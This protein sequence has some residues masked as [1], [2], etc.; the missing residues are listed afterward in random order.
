MLDQARQ[1]CERESLGNVRLQLADALSSTTIKADCVV[2][3]MVLHHFA[4]PAEAL[5]QMAG[6]LHP[7]GSLLVTDLCSHNQNWARRPAVISGWVL[8]RMIW[9]V[10]PPLRDSFPGIASM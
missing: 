3:N 4:A 2:L 1:L 5:K 6:L 8:N 10:G 9:P 7:G